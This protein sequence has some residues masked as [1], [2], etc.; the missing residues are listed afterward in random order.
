MTKGTKLFE[1]E[2]GK[3]TALKRVGKSQ[4]KILKALGCSKPLSEIT[5]KVQIRMKQENRL[6]GQKNISLQPK[7]RIDREVKK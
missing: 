4:M 2:K 3:I 6:A 1:F 7:R 5:W